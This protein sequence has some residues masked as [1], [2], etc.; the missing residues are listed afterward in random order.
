VV[1]RCEHKQ[2]KFIYLAQVGIRRVVIDRM[3][4]SEKQFYVGYEQVRLLA[5]DTPVDAGREV[6]WPASMT[7]L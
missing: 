5:C 1:V 4:T 6:R 7:D 3:M 2:G